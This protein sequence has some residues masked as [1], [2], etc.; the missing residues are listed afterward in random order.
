VHCC[1]VGVCLCAFDGILLLLVLLLVL[2][3]PSA[4]W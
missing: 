3:G 1:A 4:G 2:L